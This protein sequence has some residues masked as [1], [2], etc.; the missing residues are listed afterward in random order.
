MM[1]VGHGASY[2]QLGPADDDYR[3]CEEDRPF[4]P[5]CLQKVA[6]GALCTILTLYFLPMLSFI[7]LVLFGGVDMPSPWAP[8]YNNKTSAVAYVPSTKTPDGKWY[9]DL[10]TVTCVVLFLP[11]GLLS[12]AY[13]LKMRLIAQEESRDLMME[14]ASLG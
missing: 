7:P 14:E 11:V 8:G 1:D 6:V 3:I 2:L 12:L 9:W 13:M 10:P 5:T 4:E